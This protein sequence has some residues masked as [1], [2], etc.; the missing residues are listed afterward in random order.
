[1]RSR[2]SECHVIYLKLHVYTLFALNYVYRLKI[3][4]HVFKETYS[5]TMIRLQ[6]VLILKSRPPYIE[7]L[8][9]KLIP[10]V[11]FHVF[12]IPVI[13]LVSWHDHDRPFGLVQLRSS[14]SFLV[15]LLG[16]TENATT[17]SKFG[18]NSKSKYSLTSSRWQIPWLTASWLVIMRID[19]PEKKKYGYLSQI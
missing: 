17:L 19:A 5:V 10:K 15:V 13:N 16:T 2:S 1:M 8:N 6:K 4:P 12:M 3:I 14:V 11:L 9:L 18:P 7:L